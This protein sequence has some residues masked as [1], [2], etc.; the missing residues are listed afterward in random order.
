MKSDN[1]LPCPFCGSDQVDVLPPTLNESQLGTNPKE[2]WG[3]F[4][5]Q[6]ICFEC[7]AEITGPD[8]DYSC[9]KAISK[10]NTRTPNKAFNLLLDAVKDL[11]S[12]WTY[13]R[14]SYGDLYGVGWDRAQEKAELAL[15]E[16]Q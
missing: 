15:K 7:G 9:E 12:G 5:S 11:L 14:S 2:V 4:Y 10:W 16:V 8:F 13:I 3:K 6:V 1:L